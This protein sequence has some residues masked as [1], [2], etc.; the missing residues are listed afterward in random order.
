[1]ADTLPWWATFASAGFAACTAE[2]S[3]N[4]TK[5]EQDTDFFGKVA[6]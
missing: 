5:E 2:V 1:M 6:G 3:R 4:R